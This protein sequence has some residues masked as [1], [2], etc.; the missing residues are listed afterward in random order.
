MLAEWEGRREAL[1]LMRS[2]EEVQ[3]GEG[4]AAVLGE[5]ESGFGVWMVRASSGDCWKGP[6]E[7]GE[8]MGDRPRAERGF[9]MAGSMRGS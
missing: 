8:G 5:R 6:V 4:G 2:G 9:W 7:M 3:R 1:L